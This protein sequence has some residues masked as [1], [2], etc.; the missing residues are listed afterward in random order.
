MSTKTAKSINTHVAEIV[1]HKGPIVL[2]EDMTTENAITVLQRKQAYDAED[3]AISETINC[4]PWD[5]ALA[6]AK[7]LEEQFGFAMQEP[8]WTFF[9]PQPPRQ[10]A[11]EV[12]P[13]VTRNIP[14]G[15]FSLPG[16][17]G[18]VQT[19]TSMNSEGRL[20]FVIAGVVKH[21]DESRI[22]ELCNLVREIAARE[23]I[24]RGKAIAIRFRD[25]DGEPIGIPTPSFLA[26]RNHPAIFS[27]KLEMAI[28]TNILTPIR[29]SA[30]VR[31]SG[32]PLKR[33]ALLAGAYGTGKTLTANSVAREC[34]EHGWTFIY[35]SDIEELAMALRFAQQF[36][37]AVVFGEDI[38]RTAG[39]DR[40]DMVNEILNTLDG[41]GNKSDEIMT[42]LT[43]NHPEN[44]SPAMRRPGRID[45]V[46]EVLPPDAEAAVR[47]VQHYGKGLIEEDDLLEGVGE[48]LQGQIPA[49][50]REV[51]ERSKLESIRRT[52]SMAEIKGS[53]VL[54]AAH[55]LKAENAL[56]RGKN[57]EEPMVMR[58]ADKVGQ[59]IGRAIHVSLMEASID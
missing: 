41:I 27:H 36:Q 48:A 3:V 14:W 6:L 12:A 19:S 49:V 24:Y 32:I 15:K 25:K 51:V 5:G 50:I 52:G 47:L 4:F 9:G 44:L 28:E 31:S 56:F 57:P 42:I 43:S 16:I 29:Y 18:H 35:V 30:A 13:G 2:P 7:A 1:R 20:S 59:A 22:K 23:S 8:Q 34:E 37:P 46:L 54:Q 40:N 39:L 17:Q 10:I 58:V 53:D 38:E 26:P 45:I 11:I 55:V 33:G 21:R